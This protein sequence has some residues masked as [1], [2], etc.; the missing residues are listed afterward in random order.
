MDDLISNSFPLLA[1]SHS[2][3]VNHSHYFRKTVAFALK[4]ARVFFVEQAMFGL[5]VLLRM[6]NYIL[7][8]YPWYR[9]TVLL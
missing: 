7:C 4:Q 6:F 8:I 5:G 9:I 3:I 2:I 1:Y